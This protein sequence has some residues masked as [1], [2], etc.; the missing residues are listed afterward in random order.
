MEDA[1]DREPSFGCFCEV[2]FRL[3]QLVAFAGHPDVE[4]GQLEDADEESAEES[5]HDN[6]GEGA[7]RVRTDA[8]G[9]GGGQKSQ[10]SDQHGHDDGAEAEHPSIHGSVFDVVAAGAE[11]IDIFE[12][13]DAGLHGDAEESQETDTGRDAEMGAGKEE[14]EE[15]AERGGGDVG[16]DEQAP[17]E[18]AEHGVKNDE[19]QKDG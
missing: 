3:G 17:L 2:G 12:H 5:A 13:D 8:V 6:D 4:G 1:A 16:E 14:S 10:G 9:K 11:L 7:L 19:N 15:T 18:G